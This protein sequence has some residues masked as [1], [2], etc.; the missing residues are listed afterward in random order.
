MGTLVQTYRRSGFKVREKETRSRG[1][2][3]FDSERE[4]EAVEASRT[5]REGCSRTI[6]RHA[7]DGPA[8]AGQKKAN[9]N[10]GLLTLLTDK[11]VLVR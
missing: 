3:P 2:Y 11:D 4:K 7:S 5:E 1:F 8:A 6:L 10:A 9:R